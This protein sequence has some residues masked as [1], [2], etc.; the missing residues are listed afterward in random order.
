MACLKKFSKI[1]LVAYFIPYFAFL[2]FS[3]FESA[4]KRFPPGMF[5][6]ELPIYVFVGIFVLP[7]LIFGIPSV[8][9]IKA[10]ILS[11]RVRRGVKR[12]LQ[13]AIAS[14]VVT[15]IWGLIMVVVPPQSTRRA[16]FDIFMFLLLFGSFLW[17]RSKIKSD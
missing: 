13:I 4:E 9:S 6:R 16:V 17:L 8:A 15:I 11:D 3:N 10:E 1:I 12:K 5:N 2:L 7:V 14:I